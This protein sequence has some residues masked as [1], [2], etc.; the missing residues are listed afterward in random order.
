ME[1]KESFAEASTLG[2]KDQLETGMDPSMLT[3]FLETCMKFLCDN[4]AFK[5]LQDLI[6]R[7]AG[8]GELHVFRKLGQHALRI[9]RE[10]RLTA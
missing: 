9:G 5:G 6:T 1:A 8:S 4:K 3:T 7:C 2:S 10:M